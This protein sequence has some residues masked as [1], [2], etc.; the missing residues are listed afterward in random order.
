V[1]KQ[2]HFDTHQPKRRNEVHWIKSK[3]LSMP[4][5]IMS[6]CSKQNS[7]DQ[8]GPYVVACPVSSCD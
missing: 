7:H 6:V 3:Q 2:K 8:M 5:S 1:D 4:D